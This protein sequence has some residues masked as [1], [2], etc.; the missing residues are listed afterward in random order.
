MI[1]HIEELV[2]G[3][4]SKM[5]TLEQVVDPILLQKII[6]KYNLK[7]QTTTKSTKG[8][9]TSAKRFGM[10]Y[11]TSFRWG[12]FCTFCPMC[13]ETSQLGLISLSKWE[14]SR[15]IRAIYTVLNRKKIDLQKWINK[16]MWDMNWEVM[17]K[18]NLQVCYRHGPPWGYFK[19]I[20]TGRKRKEKWKDK[21]KTLWKNNRS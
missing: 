8:L 6:L 4:Y 21:K 13:L 1:N 16:L 5:T 18:I 10:N 12:M 15:L 11:L 3:K 17:F 7:S 20:A 2:N 14:P 19:E 9:V